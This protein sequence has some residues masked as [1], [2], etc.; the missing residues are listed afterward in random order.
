MARENA[1]VRTPTPEVHHGLESAGPARRILVVDDNRD[2]SDTLAMLLRAM[3][4]DVR[5]SHDGPS[6]IQDANAFHPQ[7]VLL[8]IGLPG[9][10]GFEV[11]RRL[12]EEYQPEA[13]LVAIS[14]YGQDEDRRRAR[15]SGFDHYFTKPVGLD[16]LRGF[17]SDLPPKSL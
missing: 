9:M 2:A 17:L 8:D 16:V 11:A 6:A 3:N 1:S 12:R 7:V 4:H 10:D 15:E 5:V 13:V 14:G